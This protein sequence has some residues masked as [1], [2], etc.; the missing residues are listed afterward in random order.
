MR[1]NLT[2][3]TRH[4]FKYHNFLLFT[5]SDLNQKI[6]FDLT[7]ILSI[8][9][10]N[11]VTDEGKLIMLKKIIKNTTGIDSYPLSK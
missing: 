11:A 2:I 4:Y 9:Y 10:T 5:M 8:L 3:K 6:E 1:H 7:H